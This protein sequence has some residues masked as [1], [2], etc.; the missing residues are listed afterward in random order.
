MQWDISAECVSAIILNIIMIYSWRSSG[1]VA[2]STKNRAF[3]ACLLVTYFSIVTNVFSALLLAQLQASNLWLNRVLLLLN[4]VFTPLMGM[5]Y[6][7]YT[8]A[9]VFEDDAVQMR[10]HVILASI[11]AILYI[12][13]VLLNPWTHLLFQI[14]LHSG[15]QRG[16]GVAL[17]Y[18]VFYVYVLFSVII[19][20]SEKKKMDEAVFFILNSFPFLSAAVIFFQYLYPT[21][22]LTGTAATSALL[23]I[24]LYLQNKQLFTDPLCGILNRQEFNRLLDI[25][26]KDKAD[27]SILVLSLKRFHFINEHF[28]QNA[29]DELLVQLAAFLRHEVQRGK[30]FRFSGDEFAI[31]CEKQAQAEAITKCIVER[32][33]LPWKL[34]GIELRVQFAIGILHI[35][36]E[37][38][39]KEE[40]IKGL[41]YAV[42]QAKKKDEQVVC[43]CTP[44]MLERLRRDEKILRLLRTCIKEDCFE[45]Y[46]QPIYDCASNTYTKAEALLRLPPHDLG[47]L[48]AEE[49]IH[50]AEE[51][52]LISDITFQVLRKTCH[53][54]RR[55]R[56]IQPDF[57]GVSV[58][59]SAVMFLQPDL[60]EHIMRILK[61]EQVENHMVKMEI[62]ESMLMKDE[63]MILRFMNRMKEKGVE[64]LLDDFGTGYSNISNVLSVPV[65]TIKIDKSLLW[66]AMVSKEGEIVLRKI[67]EAFQEVGKCML[68]EGVETKEQAAFVR[69]CHCRYI[70]GFYY[71]RPVPPQQ[72]LDIIATTHI[73]AEAG[74]KD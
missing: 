52:G 29:G 27:F 22:I 7:L 41:E 9:T 40:I 13:C 4:Y 32:M 69:E 16:P 60:E 53:F 73:Q 47:Q 65:Q 38:H 54:L 2:S 62:T 28:S 19:T 6:Y 17:T 43:E 68:V 67:C 56:A 18:I 34:E 23:I 71:A 57:Q 21:Y 14:R 49:Y 45:V 3:R 59:F 51:N 5:V 46:F 44:Q 64:F 50:L 63:M 10:H 8:I 1:S 33:Q 24:Y 20:I 58:N 70:Q 37:N 30:L 66:R 48:S 15:Y 12:G 26:I 61:E 31:V 39:Q 72:A 42:Q 74:R 55:I 11:P 25:H 35:N 36:E